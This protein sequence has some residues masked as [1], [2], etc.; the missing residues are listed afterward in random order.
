MTPLARVELYAHGEVAAW[1]AEGREIPDLLSTHDRWLLALAR[2]GRI[3]DETLIARFDAEPI[4]WRRYQA[5]WGPELRREDA[6][7]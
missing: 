2:D 5:V 4:S 7:P 6:P 1:D 3:T